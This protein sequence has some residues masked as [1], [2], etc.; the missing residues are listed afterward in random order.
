MDL[1]KEGPKRVIRGA[2]PKTIM[3]TRLLLAVVLVLSLRILAA[4]LF[5]GAPSSFDQVVLPSGREEV[6]DKAEVDPAVAML[7]DARLSGSAALRGLWLP[8]KELVRD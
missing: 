8:G 7:L 6:I 3:L 1:G 2:R 4:A 5:R